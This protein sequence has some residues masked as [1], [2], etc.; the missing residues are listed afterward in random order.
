M[1]EEA[2]FTEQLAVVARVDD[3]GLL[4]EAAIA[5]DIYYPLELLEGDSN[6]VV[7]LSSRPV[8]FRNSLIIKST[9]HTACDCRD[10]E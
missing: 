10:N 5:E 8:S 9:R 7:V 4:G 1:A 2:V 3:E 6:S